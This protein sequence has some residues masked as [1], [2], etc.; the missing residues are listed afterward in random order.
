MVGALDRDDVL[1]D[2]FGKR[3]LGDP[4]GRGDDRRRENDLLRAQEEVRRLTV[5]DE[6]PAR[7]GT[8]QPV[9]CGERLH[10]LVELVA[11]EVLVRPVEE[12]QVELGE[13]GHRGS[14]W[15]RGAVG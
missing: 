5:E 2:R 6:G 3:S 10:P 7:L 13:G 12:G 11:A 15:V 14:V 1:A 4:E 9:L 8:R